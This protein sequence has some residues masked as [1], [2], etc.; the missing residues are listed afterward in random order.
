MLSKR[1]LLLLN[2]LFNGSDLRG[3][4]F[5]NTNLNG[6]Y[7]SGSTVVSN[8]EWGSTVCP[9]GRTSNNCPEEEAMIP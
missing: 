5:I 4:K 7:F 9:D 2:A 1:L 8:T 6:A 3:A